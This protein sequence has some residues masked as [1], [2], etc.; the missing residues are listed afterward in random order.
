MAYP[1]YLM[2]V[3]MSPASASTADTFVGATL[4][5]V[6]PMINAIRF[7][8]TF[9]VTSVGS[10]IFQPLCIP[11]KVHRVGLRLTANHSDPV[12]LL[13]YKRLEGGATTWPTHV[14]G[15]ATGELFRF[16]VPTVAAS[17]K[18]VYKNVTGNVIVYPGET[19]SVA[20]STIIADLRASIALLVSPVWEQP[21]NVT[22]MTQTTAP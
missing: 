19:L 7:N 20:V 8:V 13:F 22:S 15:G 1:H 21:A 18:A 17:G 5:Q 11:H 16:M 12:D 4:G 6:V 14:P 10:G 3:K 2:E 9:N